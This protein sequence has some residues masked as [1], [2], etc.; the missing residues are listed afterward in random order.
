MCRLFDDFCGP[1]SGLAKHPYIYDLNLETII[2]ILL[3]SL[4]TL[5][6]QAFFLGAIRMMIICNRPKARGHD[7]EA[8]G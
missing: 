7:R 8:F 2:E 5:L 6:I 3:N 4:Y 1:E